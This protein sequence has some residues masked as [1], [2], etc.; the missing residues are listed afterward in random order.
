MTGV[1]IKPVTVAY[2]PGG[3]W[4]PRPPTMQLALMAIAAMVQRAAFGR[5]G[6]REDLARRDVILALLKP[7][8]VVH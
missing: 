1:A 2:A 8:G 6:V 4:L 5:R 7:K 3:D